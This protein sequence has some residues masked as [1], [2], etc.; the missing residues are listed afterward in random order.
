M[1]TSVRESRRSIADLNPQ[2]KPPSR[3]AIFTL[4]AANNTAKKVILEKANTPY[5][6][7]YKPWGYGLD[8]GT[9]LRNNSRPVLASL[10]QRGCHITV[11]R[12]LISQKVHCSFEVRSTA[13]RILLCDRS[14]H[15]ITYICNDSRLE[16]NARTFDFSSVDG[17]RMVLVDDNINPIIALG[18]KGTPSYYEFLLV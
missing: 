3:S 15:K 5:R 9:A 18:V 2:R 17:D 10:G 14:R 6:Y 8:V 4:F 12:Q 11:D 7:Y 13:Q 16:P 1:F